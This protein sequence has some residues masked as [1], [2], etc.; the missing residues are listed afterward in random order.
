MAF[1]VG[2]SWNPACKDLYAPRSVFIQ[3]HCLIKIII[4]LNTKLSP[5]WTPII[6]LVAYI[7]DLMLNSRRPRKLVTETRECVYANRPITGSLMSVCVWCPYPYT[8]PPT[9]EASSLHT[10]SYSSLWAIM[11]KRCYFSNTYDTC[12]LNKFTYICINYFGDQKSA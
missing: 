5:I 3:T 9:R 4:K 8:S 2:V 11:R 7:V 12:I 1:G 6:V 10:V